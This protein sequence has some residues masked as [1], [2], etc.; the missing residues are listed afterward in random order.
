[1]A[2]IFVSKYESPD[3]QETG[4][5]V[6]AHGRRTWQLTRFVVGILGRFMNIEFAPNAGD[7][8]GVW[9]ICP[10]CQVRQFMLASQFNEEDVT[11]GWCGG[12]FRI[13]GVEW[14]Y[15]MVGNG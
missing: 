7:M 6:E 12:R 14:P 2:R 11:C 9:P 15:T 1:M 5:L 8:I 4:Y 3:G 13:R 10:F